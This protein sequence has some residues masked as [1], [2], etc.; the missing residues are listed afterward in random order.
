MNMSLKEHKALKE[1]Q[2]RNYI[3]ITTTDKGGAVVLLDV[4]DYINKAL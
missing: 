3:I 2:S 1:L 4:N